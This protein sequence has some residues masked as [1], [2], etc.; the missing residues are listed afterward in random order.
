MRT[1]ITRP[2]L[3]ELW[4]VL[5]ASL[6]G[7]GVEDAP[8][9]ARALAI[10]AFTGRPAEARGVRVE[11][12]GEEVHVIAAEPAGAFAPRA[13]RREDPAHARTRPRRRV[14]VTR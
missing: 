3:A 7:R 1:R 8:G 5:L 6:E 2:T 9:I 11:A 4:R 13:A 12:R 10:A 14:L